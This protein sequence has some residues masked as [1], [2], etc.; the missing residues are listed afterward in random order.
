MTSFMLMSMTNQSTPRKHLQ[1]LQCGHDW[2]S[3]LT[4]RPSL[5]PNRN[6][7]HRTKWDQPKIESLEE[8]LEELVYEE[9][10]TRN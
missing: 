10:E 5:C 8:K 9:A 7:K 3:S 1:C 6:C 4:D 2:L